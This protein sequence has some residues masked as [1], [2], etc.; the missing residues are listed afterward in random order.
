[1]VCRGWTRLRTPVSRR[2][3]PVLRS[4]PAQHP[5]GVRCAWTPPARCERSNG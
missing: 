5:P 1:L 2:S 4:W 3:S